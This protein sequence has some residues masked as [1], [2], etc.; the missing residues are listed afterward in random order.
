MGPV[1]PSTRDVDGSGAPSGP[2]PTK[3]AFESIA[4]L[5]SNFRFVGLADCQTLAFR[6]RTIPH[7][8]P[9]AGEEPVTI[10]SLPRELRD[11]IWDFATK[12]VEVHLRRRKLL[13]RNKNMEDPSS[14]LPSRSAHFSSRRKH[15]KKARPRATG[16]ISTPSRISATSCGLLLTSKQVRLEAFSF[17]LRNSAFTFESP[18]AALDWVKSISSAL[19]LASVVQ[20]RLSAI[21]DHD[22]DV[23]NRTNEYNGTAAYRADRLNGQAKELVAWALYMILTDKVELGLR[24]QLWRQRFE[25]VEPRSIGKRAYIQMVKWEQAGGAGGNVEA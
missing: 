2:T 5:C 11:I 25:V 19:R 4:D 13:S 14:L 8:P 23:K 7:T 20:I 6:H 24:F 10:F 18:D 21:S 12:D 22:L 1:S 9:I 16:S 3:N 17:Y 15:N